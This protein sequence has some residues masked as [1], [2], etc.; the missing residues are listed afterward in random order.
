[1][2]DAT[3][4]L[5]LLAELGM[6]GQ[7]IELDHDP[8]HYVVH[9]CR[10]RPGDTFWA[11]D[12]AGHL[13]HLRLVTVA[14][15]VTAEVES[16]VRQPRKRECVVW[17]GAPEGT[18]ADWLVEKLAELGVGTMQPVDC[19]RSKWE[20]RPSRM[21]R[22]SRLAGSALRQSRSVYLM[23][24]EPPRRLTELLESIPPGASLWFADPDGLKR[25][26]PPEET[27]SIGMIGP[28]EGVDDRERGLLEARGFKP[29]SL[30]ESR[31]RSE[32]AAMA[33]AA[34]WASGA[35]G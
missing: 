27:M 32:T 19:A 11:T 10:A 5:V 35:D 28:A 25:V 14:P 16:R 23:R 6:P 21:A 15:S 8:A 22:W 18:R 9:V 7:R 20:A 31:L 2:A 17:C 12:G 30:G 3:P 33:W 4:S 1:M 29:I 13:A 26:S 24:I 34:W